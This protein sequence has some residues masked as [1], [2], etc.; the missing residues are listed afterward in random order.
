MGEGLRTDSGR[1]VVVNAN[2][3]LRRQA[4]ALAK[5]TL[6]RIVAAVFAAVDM[7]V[8]GQPVEP[9]AAVELET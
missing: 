2:E 5:D 6:G 9:V 8:A 1:E 4:R 7:V 3:R